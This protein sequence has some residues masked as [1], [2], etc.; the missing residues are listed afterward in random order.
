MKSAGFVLTLSQIFSA[1]VIVVLV[2]Q[3]SLPAVVLETH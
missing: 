2:S 3:L 1:V